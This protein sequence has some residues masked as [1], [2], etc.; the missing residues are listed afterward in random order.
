LT[1]SRKRRSGQ[2]KR[3]GDGIACSTLRQCAIQLHGVRRLGRA[4]YVCGKCGRDASLLVVLLH[5]A[6]CDVEVLQGKPPV[7]SSAPK[8]ES[9]AKSLV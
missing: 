5:E 7:I 6:G 1:A 2:A 8:K 4:S 3:I 9:C